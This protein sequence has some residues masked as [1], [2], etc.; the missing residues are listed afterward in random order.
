M[1]FR[2]VF[3]VAALAFALAP[4]TLPDLPG[5]GPA[6][7][8]VGGKTPSA[9][10]STP[11]THANPA[12]PTT[13]TASSRSPLTAD[14]AKTIRNL[15]GTGVLPVIGKVGGL[16]SAHGAIPGPDGLVVLAALG[17]FAALGSL[18]LLR[19]LNRI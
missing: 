6:Q 7:K 18:Y 3:A 19:R 13:R 14:A 8:A 16:T 10:T 12:L 17:S 15:P 4:A 1:R 11:T 9:P 5:M 2:A